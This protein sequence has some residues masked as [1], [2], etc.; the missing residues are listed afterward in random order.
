[1]VSKSEDLCGNLYMA[2][3]EVEKVSGQG[4][5]AK[6]EINN[7]QE[8]STPFKE[9]TSSKYIIKFQYLPFDNYL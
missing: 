6:S 3:W 1:M 9:V 7:C 2:K 5:R 4:N 8:V